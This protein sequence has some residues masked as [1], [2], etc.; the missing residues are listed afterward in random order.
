MQLSVA[1]WQVLHSVSGQGLPAWTLQ[2]P[3][4]QVSAPLQKSPSSQGAVLFGCAQFPAPS[5]WSSVHTFPS[6]VQSVPVGSKQLSVASWQV[7]HSVSG[8]GLP[9]WDEHVPALQVSFPLQ[10]TPSSQGRMLSGLLQPTPIVHNVVRTDVCVTAQ[11][12]VRRSVTGA[13]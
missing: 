7:L 5:H 2:A 12:V 4:L 3:P 13:A 6:S 1:S 11:A 10:K 9:A 8:Q